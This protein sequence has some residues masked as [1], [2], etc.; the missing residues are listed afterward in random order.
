V[1]VGAVAHGGHCVARFEG[2]VVFV[3]HTLPG[4]RVRARVT[5]GGAGSSFLRAD[6]VEVLRPSSDRVPVRC[7]VAGP[8]GCGGCDWQ[9]VSVDG[10]HRLK[11]AVVHE[12]LQRL[13]HVDVPVVVEAVPGDHSGL[14]WR[15]RVQYTVAD[16][17]RLGF[18]RHR[19]HD[20]V[21]VQLCPIAAPAVQAMPVTAARWPGVRAVE[22]VSGSRPDDR[23]VVVRGP[24]EVARRQTP[25]GPGLLVDDVTR[26]GRTPDRSGPPR[27]ERG[28][29]WVRQVV[30][31]KDWQRTFRVSGSG[32]WQ[33]H[34][35]AA[36]TLVTAVL[37][38][39][40]P[41]PGERAL[42]L[43]AGAGL[44]TAAL[45]DRVGPSGRVVA[46]EADGGAVRDARRNLHDLPWVRLVA[47]RVDAVLRRAADAAAG[48]GVEARVDSP[49]DAGV[50]LVVLDP[51]RTG[52]RAAVVRQVAARR[53]RAVAY[54][55]CDPAALGR[56]VALF[57]EHGYRLA[58][59]R[60]FD[61]FPMTQ[62]VECVALLVENISTSR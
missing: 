9:H 29:G 41:Q 25:K 50:D 28:R 21:P 31:A 14:G 56:D 52:A 11:A 61:A 33:V 37:E 49:A 1:E 32:F 19:S 22:V 44:F 51:P 15:T 2:Q 35:G 60:A 13:G 43:Y 58:G 7:P 40:D 12:Q 57:A 23:V 10:Q 48:P 8:G 62:H 5:D 18:R 17:G 6:A 30:R 42:D 27:R 24:A 53:P 47:G 26:A 3:R 36:D 4:E 59:V 45:A 39:L 46:I 20:V 55:A 16:D 34:P 38:A 54:V